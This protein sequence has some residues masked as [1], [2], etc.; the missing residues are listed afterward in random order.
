MSDNSNSM[1]L[2]RWTSLDD[3]YDSGQLADNW[4]KVAEH[5]H[6]SGKGVQIP[7]AGIAPAATAT[8]LVNG[9]N[10]DTVSTKLVLA[11]DTRLSDGR[12]PDY[13]DVTWDGTSNLAL[14][15]T[16]TKSSI[17]RQ[18][19]TLSTNKTVTLPLYNSLP[20]GSEVIIQSGNLSGGVINVRPYSGDKIN[21]TTD[22]SNVNIGV[23]YAF[24]RF[25]N[26]GIS[27]WVFDEGVLRTSN[28]L[29]ELIATAS[30]ARTNLGLGSIA[31]LNAISTTEITNGTIL[32]A[33]INS[34]AGI[35]I[36]KLSGSSSDLRGVISDE[37]G[38]GPLV[39][40]TSPTINGTSTSITNVGTFALRDTSAAYDVT[41][42]ATSSTTLTTG[43]TL[44]LDLVNASKTLKLGGNITTAGNFT[45][46]G[47]NALALT[48]TATTN[49]TLPSGN[50]TL[51]ATDSTDVLTNKS[52]SDT[53]TFIVDSTD[54]TK[55]LN[56]DVTGTT[57]IT[58]VLQTAFT[59]AKTIAFPDTAGTVITSGDTN[60]V[61]NTILKSSA[62]TDNLRAVTTD[63][64]RD[65]AVT[66]A[67]IATLS[68]DP[69]GT[70]YDKVTVN[71]KGQVTAGVNIGYGTSL[72]V[73]PLAGDEYYYQADAGNNVI[74]HL[75]CNNATTK[76]WEFLGGAPLAAVQNT[77]TSSEVVSTTYTYNG[78]PGIT[79]PY[80]PSITVPLTGIYR[81]EFGM[82][83]SNTNANK[84]TS[85]GLT[86]GSTNWV[87]TITT[88]N[89][90][91]TATLA[92]TVSG[93][94]T[95]GMTITSANVPANTTVTVSGTTIT[96][97][98]PASANG[99]GTAATAVSLIP[100]AELT[101]PNSA[102][103][104]FYTGAKFVHYFSLTYGTIYAQFKTSGN[105][106]TVSNRWIS[107]TPARVG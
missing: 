93:T 24:R 30:T 3:P 18:T 95:T 77:G 32:D 12:P 53:T 86:T 45:T 89:N 10:T 55:K 49:A 20:A 8:T 71:N 97:S 75:R 44:T 81:M 107:I 60:T 2:V 37:T 42:A 14:Q 28:N 85:M 35:A 6:E 26:D 52:L 84:I 9:K 36:T 61:T 33:D 65:A 106:S 7:F 62:S 1:G 48:T 58:G 40:G 21:G 15:G 16:V 63:H 103:N 59:T 80:G 99:T 5:T 41:I 94:L 38:S 13:F 17:V 50:V 64:I 78:N 73:S 22:N 67:K 39:F 19:G 69:T 79:S 96:L 4:A 51:V 105:T 92:S 34:S 54:N 31:T 100:G 101:I 90:S 98:N 27:G 56:I 66:T 25:I 11:N 23:S 68:P 74:W 87:G 43:R 57:G 76:T 46:V 29:S 91:T 72:P 70:F 102:T 104:T 47:T 88:T 83:A 82:D